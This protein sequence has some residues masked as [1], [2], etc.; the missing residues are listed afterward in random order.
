MAAF[1]AILIFLMVMVPGYAGAELKPEPIPNVKKLMA[2]YPD[3]WMFVHD[4]N[5]HTMIAGKI[6]I[7][8]V[9]AETKQLKGALGAAQAGMFRQSLTRPELYVAETFLSRGVEGERTD[10]L[11]YYDTTT[12]DKIGEVI[13]PGGKRAQFVTQ[14]A[15]FILTGDDRLG[16]VANF[17]P[18]ASVT[19]VDMV[20]RRVLN[21]IQLPGC[22][23]LYASGEHGFATLCSN[24]TMASYVLG[25]EGS[26]TDR[27]VTA[28]FNNID[29]DAMFMKSTTIGGLEYF[30]TFTG[31]VQPIN[32]SGKHPVIMDSWSLVTKQERAGNWRPGGWQILTS[33]AAGR[34]YVLMQPDGSEGSHK[35]GGPEVWVFDVEAQKRVARI[36]LKTHGVSIEATRSKEPVLVVTNANMELDVYDAAS[37]KWL[38]MIGGGLAGDPVVLF[39]V[40]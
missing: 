26:A 34:L 40:E 18:A 36:T 20:E 7:V 35:N 38:R 37:G 24:G 29:D 33:D 16:L 25:E 1:R 14:K 5:F 12:L 32:L 19:I 22:M 4:L 15:A 31:N 23:L 2:E 30:V 9:A 11:T 8:D 28:P 17:T 13:L 39:A 27:H 6:L 10:V 21:E 3:S